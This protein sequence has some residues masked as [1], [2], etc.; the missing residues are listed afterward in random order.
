MKNEVSDELDGSNEDED[1]SANE[2]FVGSNG[3]EGLLRLE[4]SVGGLI[5][6]EIAGNLGHDDRRRDRGRH[7]QGNC[8]ATI[9]AEGRYQTKGRI[10]VD[11]GK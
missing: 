11:M 5:G 8:L 6:I 2:P 3:V 1:A 7:Y 10:L 4:K 9:I